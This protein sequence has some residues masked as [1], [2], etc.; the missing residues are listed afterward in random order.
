MASCAPMVKETL[1]QGTPSSEPRTSS[2]GSA[3]HLGGAL[4]LG[5]TFLVGTLFGTAVGG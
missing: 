4:A 1:R 2:W 3:G 5:A